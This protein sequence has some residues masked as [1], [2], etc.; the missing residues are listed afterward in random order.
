MDAIVAFLA[1]APWAVYALAFLGPFV[2]EDAAVLGAA[3]AAAAGQGDPAGLFVATFLGLLASDGWKYWVGYY[4]HKWPWA[5]RQ[6]EKPSVMKAREEV[7]K[8]LFLALLTARFV[9]G[10]RIPLYVAAGY[11]K[12]PF[13]RFLVYISITGLAYLIVAFG[14]LMT[15]GAAM[16]EQVQAVLPFVVGGI[17]AFVLG[18]LF[19]K[20]RRSAQE[21]R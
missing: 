15:L 12:A 9:P 17:I 5:A 14:V 8:R 10:T 16:G 21:P 4:A 13:W 6:A 11:F 2:Q 3:A 18:Y 7:V 19:W 1:S 20:S